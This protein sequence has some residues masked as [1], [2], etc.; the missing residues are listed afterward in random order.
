ML[1]VS[2]KAWLL[3]LG[4]VWLAGL[5]LSKTHLSSVAGCCC[6]SHNNKEPFLSNKQEGLRYSRQ[7]LRIVILKSA[8]IW[9]SLA[10][11]DK[12]IAE[13]IIHFRLES[14][15]NW[16][17]CWELQPHHH[18]VTIRSCCVTITNLQQGWS[19]C[20]SNQPPY[21]TSLENLYELSVAL[22]V[23]ANVA[24]PCGHFRL[25]A[26]NAPQDVLDLLSV[27]Y[28]PMFKLACC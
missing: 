18:N 4:M 9:S 20:Q 26:M 14:H 23:N 6:H 19:W 8:R 28:V 1:L 17:A 15:K 24:C 7:N 5:T 16:V 11:V 13:Y 2:S 10:P 12:V 3:W 22:V 25:R 21:R 27:F